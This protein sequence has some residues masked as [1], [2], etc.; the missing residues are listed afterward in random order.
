MSDILSQLPQ[1]AFKQANSGRF[2]PVLSYDQRCAAL[3]LVH[4]NVVRSVI[5]AAF[6]VNRRTISHIANESSIHYRDVRAEYKSMGHEAFLKKYLREEHV[7]AVARAASKSAAAHPDVSARA[8]K[9]AGMHTVKPEQ[10]SYSH[11]IE[12]AYFTDQ[13][14]G[15]GW[16]F[17]D[18]ESVD[19]DTWLHNG[20]DSR[21]TSQACYKAVL[22]NITDE[23]GIDKSIAP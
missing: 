9:F 23:I 16:Y 8:N 1:S 21:R 10:C 3:A 5:A 4:S 11:R 6:G 13:P 19:R 2:A 7:Q 14:D 22:D 20:E 15:A 17:R 12:I 18:L